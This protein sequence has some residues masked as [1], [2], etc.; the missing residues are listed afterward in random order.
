MTFVYLCNFSRHIA[1]EV[2][3]TF[4]GG[5]LFYKHIS[6]E[7]N[8]FRKH[9]PRK[10]TLRKIAPQENCS[11]H[12]CSLEKLNSGILPSQEKCP[13]EKSPHYLEDFIMFYY[14][15]NSPQTMLHSIFMSMYKKTLTQ[16]HM[17]DD[18]LCSNKW[19]E[20]MLYHS[21]QICIYIYI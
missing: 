9:P 1:K 3:R 16:R 4:E 20:S 11:P 7:L 12:T 14:I 18:I 6:H 19:C 2:V 15:F 10:N 13:K 8:G 17:D 21:F 5:E